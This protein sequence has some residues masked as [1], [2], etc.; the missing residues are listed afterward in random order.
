MNKLLAEISWRGY[1]LVHSVGFMADWVYWGAHHFQYLG[2][3]R[4]F[5]RAQQ[6]HVTAEEVWQHRGIAAGGGLQTG[7]TNIC[8]AKCSFCA[9]P[10]AVASKSLQT[11]IMPLALFK[12]AV[13][14]WA[15]LGGAGLDLTPVV[16]DPLV[17]PGLLEKVDY[18][19]HY[20]R[21]KNVV[22]T[23]NAILINHQDTYKKLI[24]AGITS[25]FISTQGA[26]REEYEKIY[27]VKQYDKVISGIHNLLRYNHEKGEP[28][29]IVI[30]FRNAEK[31]SRI[32]RSPDF[33]QYIRPFLSRRTRINFTVDFDNWGG[34]I[35]P[36]DI[37]GVMRL[38]KIPPR[39]DLP[40]Q[41][42]F[43]FTVRHEGSVR[44]CGC[45]FVRTDLDDLVVGNIRQ[46]TLREISEG[47]EAWKII[48]GFYSGQRPESCQQC[49]FYRPVDRAWLDQR[50][51]QHSPTAANPVPPVPATAAKATA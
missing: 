49:T 26:S 17:D 6:E 13:D 35:Q 21:M 1:S 29:E 7:V 9:Y 16:G 46:K 41:S 23:T 10:K 27:G 51:R 30:R 15:A 8:N 34:S 11:G 42:L 25:V 43:S 32:L 20:A 45:R 12:Q 3:Q 47:D 28:T 14:E 4:A 31:P 5:R 40:C 39:V 38:R 33:Q 36:A 50:S 22:L 37:S 44:L 19:L 24:D 48:K 2:R 18:A